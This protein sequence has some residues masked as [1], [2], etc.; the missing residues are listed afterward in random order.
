MSPTME[1]VAGWLREAAGKI[2]KYGPSH[3]LPNEEPHQ[4]YID[5]KIAVG[6]FLDLAAQVEAM[7]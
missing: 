4:E 1:E 3:I 6:L 2:N 5:K 7:G